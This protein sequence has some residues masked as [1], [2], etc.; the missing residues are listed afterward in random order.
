MENCIVDVIECYNCHTI[1]NV[2]NDDI[3]EEYYV[4]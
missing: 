1:I 4:I 3:H 2:N